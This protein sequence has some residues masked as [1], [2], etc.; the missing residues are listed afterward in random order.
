M[1]KTSQAVGLRE[2][3]K[4]RNSIEHL[5]VISAGKHFV[6]KSKQ[7]FDLVKPQIRVNILGLSSD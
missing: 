2:L 1:S 7:V 3:A 5:T 4:E 6:R